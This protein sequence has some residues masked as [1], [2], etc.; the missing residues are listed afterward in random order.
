[1]SVF[2]VSH[3]LSPLCKVVQPNY[4][5]PSSPAC[6]FPHAVLRIMCMRTRLLL[7]WWNHWSFLPRA[8]FRSDSYSSNRY[9]IFCVSASLFPDVFKLT[10]SVVCSI[11]FRTPLSSS[12]CPHFT[13]ALGHCSD[14]WLLHIHYDTYNIIVAFQNVRSFKV[15][16]CS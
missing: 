10:R 16:C 7:I 14:H 13:A 4:G 5:W 15:S 6:T 3:K 8:I 1:M 12:Q 11:T 2:R 9:L